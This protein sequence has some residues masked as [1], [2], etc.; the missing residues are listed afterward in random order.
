MVVE[1]LSGPYYLSN[2][3]SLVIVICLCGTYYQVF[4]ILYHRCDGVY[5][6]IMCYIR[7]SLRQKDYH[8][9]PKIFSQ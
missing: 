2:F 9:L 8:I 3:F 5:S 4:M 7:S 6:I 1:L